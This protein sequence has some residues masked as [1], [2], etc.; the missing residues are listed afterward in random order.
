MLLLLSHNYRNQADSSSGSSGSL[1]R[2]GCGLGLSTTKLDLAHWA[3]SMA[4]NE[5]ELNA[6][7]VKNMPTR[8]HAHMF[9]IHE[10]LNAYRAGPLHIIVADI[11]VSTADP[12]VSIS[13]RG[14]RGKIFVVVNVF[15][16]TFIISWI[17]MVDLFRE[18]LVK[19]R[20][21]ENRRWHFFSAT[22]TRLPTAIARHGITILDHPAT[23]M[24]G[25]S[26]QRGPRPEQICFDTGESGMDFAAHICKCECV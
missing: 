21:A 22:A 20:G 4:L 25:L 2:T 8:K 17:G 15:A 3:N 12:C 13:G 26:D 7:G 10:L 5:P 24:G 16:V 23:I 18:Q 9:T 11:L 14:W 6:I 19:I 1:L